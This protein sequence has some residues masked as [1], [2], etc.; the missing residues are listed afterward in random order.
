M[1]TGFYFTRF[2]ITLLVGIGMFTVYSCSTDKDEPL[3][4]LPTLSFTMLDGNDAPSVL[5][6]QSEEETL[7]LFISSN[8]TWKVT[9]KGDDTDWLTVTPSE[10]SKDGEIKI[11]ASKNTGINDR[12]VTLSFSAGDKDN[13]KSLKVLQKGYG[14]AL[15]VSHDISEAV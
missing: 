13:F 1:K 5:S 2:L 3:K 6:V 8:S 12:E 4:E 15:F 10:G 11:T 9:K 14:P 7:S